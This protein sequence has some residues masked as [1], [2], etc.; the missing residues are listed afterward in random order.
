MIK[1]RWQTLA[2]IA[3]VVISASLT[4]SSGKK[5]AP[6]NAVALAPQ[7]SVEKIAAPATL[8][9]NVSFQRASLAESAGAVKHVPLRIWTVPDPKLSAFAALAYSL[10]DNFPLWTANADSVWPIA[11]LTKLVTA[12]VVLEETG[13]NKKVTVDG[14]MLAAYGDAGGLQANEE[15]VSS[16]LLKIMLVG[17][18]NDAARAFAG[19]GESMPI[20]VDFARL[21]REKTQKIGMAA[22]R[23]RDASG[24][25]SENTGSVSDIFRL[26]R[27]IVENHPQIFA[28][29]RLPNVLIQPLNE[30]VSHTIANVNP[31]VG[32]QRFLG[33]KTG[34]LPEAKENFAGLF[35]L[36]DRRVAVVI[37]GSENRVRDVNALLEWVGRAYQF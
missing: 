1:E 12:V 34:T 33:G 17:S 14:K 35:T 19:A 29:T 22:T 6:E 30:P 31:F 4:G 18:S 26:I 36:H 25:S 24:L 15:Y 21:L 10:D 37:L 8:P 16:D 13:E 20:S 28:W 2:L 3:V 32:D 9:E 5:Q 27:Y 23:L 11:S 7:K